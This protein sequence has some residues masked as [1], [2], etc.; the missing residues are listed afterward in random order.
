MKL[1]MWLKFIVRFGRGLTGCLIYKLEVL[2]LISRT[3]VGKKKPARCR[4]ALF[5]ILVLESSTG[6]SQALE[7]DSQS[8]YPIW[9]VPGLWKMMLQIKKVNSTYALCM[10]VSVV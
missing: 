5:V 9:L 1:L 4:G 6:N 10:W 7:F 2:N 8:S 3:R